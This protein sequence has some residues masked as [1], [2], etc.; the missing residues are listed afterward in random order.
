MTTLNSFFIEQEESSWL[1][2]LPTYQKD[3]V[4]ELLS[5]NSL[6]E[7]AVAW[8]DASVGNTSPF[9]AQPQSE[10]K[11]FKLLKIEAHK[12]LCGNPEYAL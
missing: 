11:Y 1:Y 10:K 2:A 5:S 6:E 12:L 4:A 3:I 7:V 8:L 9:S